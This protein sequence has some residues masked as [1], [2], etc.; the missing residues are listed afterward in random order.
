MLIILSLDRILMWWTNRIEMSG[1]RSCQRVSSCY[2]GVE[3]GRN[4]ARFIGRLD[5]TRDLI[6]SIVSV[7]FNIVNYTKRIY[8]LRLHMKF[9]A[10]EI[11]T[12][13]KQKMQIC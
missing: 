2:I 10:D 11:D 5:L 1:F 4:F 12:F 3:L 9:Q 6:D 8:A 7:F 13:D